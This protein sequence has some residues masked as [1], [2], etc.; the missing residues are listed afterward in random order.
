MAD[1]TFA[2]R[3]LLDPDS[4]VVGSFFEQY[5]GKGTK[6]NMR[7]GMKF[8]TPVTMYGWFGQYKYRKTRAIFPGCEC[9][10]EEGIRQS[11]VIHFEHIADDPFRVVMSWHE[12][13]RWTIDHRNLPE[14]LKE[15]ADGTYH[16]INSY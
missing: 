9:I 13:G 11:W 6:Y 5:F 10:P 2:V 8:I 12:N 4:T 15:I 1:R 14:V 16:I 3:E 7:F